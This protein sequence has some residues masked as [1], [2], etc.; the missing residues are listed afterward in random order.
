MMRESSFR[1]QSRVKDSRVNTPLP[2]ACSPTLPFLSDPELWHLAP[3]CWTATDRDKQRGGK[4]R[5]WND[6][7]TVSPNY[8]ETNG[9]RKTAFLRDEGQHTH[10]ITGVPPVTDSEPVW[11]WNSLNTHPSWARKGRCL[12]SCWARKASAR[13]SQTHLYIY[14]ASTAGWLATT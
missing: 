10:R 4:L 6:S 8:A 1:K 9:H 13:R 7:I 14:G 11:I 3:F 5:P 12:S 2:L